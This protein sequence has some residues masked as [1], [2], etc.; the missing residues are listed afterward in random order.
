[1]LNPIGLDTILGGFE[2]P[3]YENCVDGATDGDIEDGPNNDDSGA[4]DNGV[5]EP[6]EK[7]RKRKKLMVKRKFAA[8]S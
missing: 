8:E 4:E 3:T 5:I 6:Q 2:C 1:M 7:M